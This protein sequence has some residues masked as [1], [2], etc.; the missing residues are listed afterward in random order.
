MAIE[1]DFY[2]RFT[3]K[4]FDQTTFLARE[5]E[6]ANYF[7]INRQIAFDGQSNRKKKRQKKEGKENHIH[8][9]KSHKETHK[10]PIKTDCQEEMP[11]NA[12]H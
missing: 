7:V 12:F 3:Q 11:Q 10:N 2:N 1:F 5:S 9:I 8:K 6:I 4:H